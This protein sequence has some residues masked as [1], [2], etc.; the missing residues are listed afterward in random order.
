MPFS[1]CFIL[2]LTSGGLAQRILTP[3]YTVGVVALSHIDTAS[4]IV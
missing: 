3:K 2:V 4:L 1:R